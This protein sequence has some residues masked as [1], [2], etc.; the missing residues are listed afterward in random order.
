MQTSV[1]KNCIQWDALFSRISNTIDSTLRNKDFRVRIG[2]RL[3]DQKSKEYS[4]GLFML[5]P[6]EVKMPGK[7]Q[8]KR[9]RLAAQMNPVGPPVA[10]PVSVSVEPVPGPSYFFYADS[11]GGGDVWEGSEKED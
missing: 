10:A 2:E 9:I 11:S 3:K 4:P 1:P 5:I 7:D 8:R 6:Q